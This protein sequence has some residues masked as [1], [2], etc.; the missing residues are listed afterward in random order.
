MF[1]DG[2][3][4]FV[5]EITPNIELADTMM[6]GLRLDVGIDA[7]LFQQRFGR[8]LDQVFATEIA[9]LTGAGLLEQDDAGIRLTRA[10]K[11]LG[12]NVFERFVTASA[13]VEL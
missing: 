10:G 5:E 1:D 7:G 6:M 12:N 8:S 3:V 2:P 9:E 11:L 13:D 4:D